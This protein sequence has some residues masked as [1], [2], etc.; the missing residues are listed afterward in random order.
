MA[1]SD[2][3]LLKLDKELEHI[4][5]TKGRPEI[6]MPTRKT[7]P[8]FR[9]KYDSAVKRYNNSGFAKAAL[10]PA[11]DNPTWIEAEHNVHTRDGRTIKART[12]TPKNLPA[13][14][15]AVVVV[16]HG[17][18]WFMGSLVTDEFTC[19]LFCAKLGVMV[20]NVD[21][22]LYPEVPFP[23]P[24]LDCHDA[25][26]WTAHETPKMGANLS[27]GFIV[28]GN[29]GGGTYA[30][31]VAHLARDDTLPSPLTGCHFS[32]P[33]FTDETGDE[34]GNPTTVFDHETEYRSWWQNADAPL[35][36]EKMRMGIREFATY[37]WKS[38]LL[39]PFHFSSHD[40]LPPTYL[41]VCG[42]DPWRDG[43]FIYKRELEKAGCTVKL[44]CY[45]GMPHSWWTTYPQVSRTQDWLRDT[46][47][48]MK[49]L[50]NQP[51][52]NSAVSKL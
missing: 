36:N 17:G 23:V 7:I 11:F 38:P 1:Y 39:T 52:K 24:I 43:G 41:C 2:E 48:G 20:V 50:L 3:E 47:D 19:R 42:L 12:Y 34:H 28:S 4:F 30:S 6:T 46:I 18:G 51:K 22:G 8:V 49:W 31:I 35:M 10:G 5:N 44:D 16:M 33:I 27:K 15:V 40:N 29:S 26:K 21:F 45:P 32:C 14:G 9:K 25:V 37:D 13:D